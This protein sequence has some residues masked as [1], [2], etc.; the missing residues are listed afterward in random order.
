[1]DWTCTDLCK[2]IC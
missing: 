2:Q 1:M